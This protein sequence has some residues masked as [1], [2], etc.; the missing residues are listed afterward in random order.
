MC[1][2]KKNGD[3]LKIAETIFSFI[4]E[5][6]TQVNTELGSYRKHII[7]GDFSFGR[8]TKHIEFGNRMLKLYKNHGY[9]RIRNE[10]R[11]DQAALVSVEEITP[12]ASL[13]AQ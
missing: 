5:C 12:L 4:E 3:G 11:C 2:S 7:D 10:N 6:A 13:P 1:F 8:I 9:L